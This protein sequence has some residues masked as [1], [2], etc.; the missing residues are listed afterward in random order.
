MAAGQQGRAQRSP[1][2]NQF[3]DLSI[4]MAMENIGN[5]TI[6]TNIHK[7]VCIYVHVY[8][9]IFVYIYMYMY[10]YIYICLFI[11]VY[12][13]IFMQKY[14]NIYYVFFSISMYSKVAM[15]NHRL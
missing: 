2:W 14:Q 8:I 3:Q 11:Y 7:Y 9:Y 1:A 13:Y 4:A 5:H 15:D 12:I 6:Y 10:I